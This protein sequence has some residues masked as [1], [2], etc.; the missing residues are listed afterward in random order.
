MQ[1]ALPRPEH[2]PFIATALVRK[3]VGAG[4]PSIDSPAPLAR[5][6][7]VVV[8]NARQPSWVLGGGDMTS[9]HIADRRFRFKRIRRWS[10]IGHRRLRCSGM[11]GTR[12]ASE[13]GR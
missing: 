6:V 4:G 10:F 1:A 9:G 8:P 7:V 5:K 11:C 3:S 2:W 12:K 13:F